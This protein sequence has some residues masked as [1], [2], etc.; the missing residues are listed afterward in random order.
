[1]RFV[2]TSMRRQRLDYFLP[3]S[4]EQ[5]AQPSA[6]GFFLQQ[7]QEDKLVMTMAASSTF[8]SFMFV[9]QLGSMKGWRIGL[10]PS[11]V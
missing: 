4:A 1:M 7:A 11:L 10:Q 3:F 8:N 5:L 2:G 6:A 9:G